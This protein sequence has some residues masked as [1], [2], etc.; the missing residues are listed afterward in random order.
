MSKRK[1]ELEKIAS[2]QSEVVVME[3]VEQSVTTEDITGKSRNKA[4]LGRDESSNEE[5]DQ[6]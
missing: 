5:S 4:T 1:T 3:T 6:D 2:D